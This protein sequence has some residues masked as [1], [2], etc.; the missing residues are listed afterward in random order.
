MLDE[1]GGSS[2]DE[3]PDL[4]VII[5]QYRHKVRDTAS[6]EGAKENA[7]ITFN[8][9]SQTESDRK[10]LPNPTGKATPLRRRKLGQT[11]SVDGFL[12]K[13]W[14]GRATKEE[15][16]RQNSNL[17][18]CHFRASSPNVNAYGVSSGDTSKSVP[19][20]T[21]K[22]SL[23]TFSPDANRSTSA[24][25][26]PKQ[27][28]ADQTGQA[29]NA[30]LSEEIRE[31]VALMGELDDGESDILGDIK[32]PSE[33]GSEFVSISDSESDTW[34]SDFESSLLPTRRSKIPTDEWA[35]PQRTLFAGPDKK[36]ASE[37]KQ[38]KMPITDPA[39]PASK[40]RKQGDFHLQSLK[41]S[42]PGNLE[43]AF[44][45]LKIFNEDSELD[46]PSA[47]GDR[48]P[49]PPMEPITPR[50]TLKAS[51]SK[52]PKIP[53]SPWK[54]EHKEFWDPEENFGWIDKHSPEKRMESPRKKQVQE[55]TKA[56][57]KRT[58]A[59]KRATKKA[60]DAAKEEMARSFLQELDCRVT[61]GQ[62]SQLTKDTGGLQMTWS[63]QLL[64]TAGRA[65]WKCK[66][67]PAPQPDGSIGKH[68][69]HYATIELA[70]KVLNNETDLLNTVAHE[71]CHLAVFILNGKPKMAHGSEFKHWGRLCGNAFKDRGIVVT[72]KHNYDIEYKYV[73]KCTD[74]AWEVKRHSK[75]V[76]TNQH[77]CGSCK[78]YLLQIKP[79]PRNQSPTPS[80]L[81]T[82]GENGG[83]LVTTTVKKQ[84]S[85]WQCFFARESKILAQ[86]NKGLT[87]K[88][89]MARI[90]AKWRTLSPEEKKSQ[91]Q[92]APTEVK[93][94]QSAVEIL[95]IDDEEL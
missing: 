89:R 13:P 59:E 32:E 7:P 77:R 27:D 56:G 91:G 94:L 10:E 23:R 51:P 76:D 85:M 83:R 46:E 1:Y 21:D 2:E 70:T 80:R 60:F 74:C 65:H 20:I 71:F 37:N 31:L 17:G 34:N 61:N 25:E 45:K 55:S 18:G 57:M 87:A 6:R 11:Q 42:H 88:E 33:E 67:I 54:P 36:P 92:T 35:R 26:K 49:L 30:Q 41:A 75:S 48:K 93:E 15:K 9:R 52:A 95:T 64:S 3:F 39:K 22:A 78:G 90:S 44:Q 63:N 84:P 40:P 24:K 12:L 19:A 69:Q 66:T 5:R 4:D 14:N 16:D 82:D 62:L 72:T 43:D 73:W 28:E 8:P 38:T 29:K 68:I 86:T 50:K 47:G 58:N 81:G 79:T 53:E